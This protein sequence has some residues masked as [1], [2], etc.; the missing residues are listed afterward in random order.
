MG[1]NFLDIL[2]DPEVNN[3]YILQIAQPSKYGYTKLQYRFAVTSGSPSIVLQEEF[4]D[5]I[6]EMFLN[7]KFTEPRIKFK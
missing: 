1:H 4:A 5:Q 3:K 2:G 7:I 6:G